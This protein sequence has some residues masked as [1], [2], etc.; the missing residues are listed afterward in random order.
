MNITFLEAKKIIKLKSKESC[1]EISIKLICSFE[2]NQLLIYLKA[3]FALKG[4]KLDV[5]SLPFDTLSQYLYENELREKEENEILFICDWD[6]YEGLN[7][8][9]GVPSKIENFEEIEKLVVKKYELIKNNSFT[10]IIY[11]PFETLH[12]I[13]NGNLNNKLNNL[14][15]EKVIKLNSKFVDSVNLSLNNFLSNGFPFETN[16]LS[17]VSEEIYNLRFLEKEPKKILITDLDNTFWSGILGEDGKENISANPEGRSY[18]FFI[19][20]TLLKRLSQN[21]ILICALSKN[22]I[23]DIKE[24]FE[25]NNFIFEYNDFLSVIGTYEPKSIQIENLLKNLNL[26]RDSFIFID[27]NHLEIEEVS[28]MFGCNSCIQFPSKTEQFSSF[29]SNLMSKFISDKKSFEDINRK[30][31]Y[32]IRLKGLKALKGKT[33]NI[34]N[35]LIELSMQLKI[36]FPISDDMSRGIQLINKTNQ[37]NLN[38]IRYSENEVKKIINEGGSLITGSLN[39]RFGNHGEIISLLV[40]NSGLIISYVMSCRVFQREIEYIFLNSL[41]K[42]PFLNFKFHYLKTPKNTPF[43]KFLEQYDL[44]YENDFINLKKSNIL[45]IAESKKGII[46][47]I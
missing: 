35:Y 38:G 23:N 40:N 37:F 5:E 9:R 16:Q 41:N 12:I 30:E 29:L 47:I 43:Q 44:S 18:L 22:E 2:L 24:A 17:L 33:Q 8:R 28:K 45:A 31:L 15:R 27:D 46:E 20:Q 21:G 42:F 10:K 7:W 25:F 32:R 6:F 1:E 13:E 34:R 11:F 39:D 19:Y 36:N 26:M 14:I 4:Y 3:I